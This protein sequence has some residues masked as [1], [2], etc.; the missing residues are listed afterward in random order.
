M[1]K[2]TNVK[3]IANALKRLTTPG[4][5][6]EPEEPDVAE[7]VMTLVQRFEALEKKTDLLFDQMANLSAEVRLAIQQLQRTSSQRPGQQNQPRTREDYA[8][9]GAQMRPQGQPSMRQTSQPVTPLPVPQSPQGLP[10]ESPKSITSGTA[11]GRR[12]R[13]LHKAVCADCRKDCEVPIKPT[14]GRPVYCKACFMLRKSA[15]K[16][17]PSRGAADSVPPST[18]TAPQPLYPVSAASDVQADPALTARPEVFPTAHSNNI[19]RRNAVAYMAK[20]AGHLSSPQSASSQP[21]TA[22]G[23]SRGAPVSRNQSRP[24]PIRN[25]RLKPKKK[26]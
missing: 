11:R 16:P 19:A 12:D 18:E 6:R 17:Q 8:A 9:R 7:T 21:P 1:K 24:R 5:A 25:D 13:L 23:G 22:R 20:K 15:S 10:P 14:E 26:S 2:T 3:K 4:A